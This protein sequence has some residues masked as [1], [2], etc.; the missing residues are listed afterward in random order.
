MSFLFVFTIIWVYT[1]CIFHKLYVK[2][3]ILVKLP[4]TVSYFYLT[5]SSR[6]YQRARNICKQAWKSTHLYTVTLTG[7]S[8]KGVFLNAARNLSLCLECCG[9]LYFS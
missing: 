9:L 1:F 7:H 6:G 4:Y 5:L 3:Y 2:S 8:L